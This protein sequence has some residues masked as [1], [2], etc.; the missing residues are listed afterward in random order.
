MLD[1]SGNYHPEWWS[2]ELSKQ[3]S[4]CLT[5]I[6]WTSTL[7]AQI[8]SI[9]QTARYTV[10]LW[11]ALQKKSTSFS[12]YSTVWQPKVFLVKRPGSFESFSE[13]WVKG[14][15]DVFHIFALNTN[16]IPGDKIFKEINLLL[17]KFTLHR[18][19]IEALHCKTDRYLLIFSCWLSQ[20]RQYISPQHPRTLSQMVGKYGI[21]PSFPSR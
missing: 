15:V 20:I 21:Y 10:S 9:S 4:I 7:M 5:I 13:I 6:S 19:T 8:S 17:G 16:A 3:A 18:F 12:A 11:K 2:A 1:W 14:V